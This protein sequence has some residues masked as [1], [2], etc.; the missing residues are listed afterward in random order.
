MSQP[1]TKSYPPRPNVYVSNPDDGRERAVVVDVANRYVFA[2]VLPSRGMSAF[3]LANSAIEEY[4]RS[5]GSYPNS[6]RDPVDATMTRFG[7]FLEQYTSRV[8]L[9]EES[10]RVLG[11]P[12]SQYYSDSAA[13]TAARLGQLVTYLQ[14]VATFTALGPN[15]REAVDALNQRLDANQESEQELIKASAPGSTLDGMM[16]LNVEQ[17]AFHVAA[18]AGISEMPMNP[19]PMGQPP[20]ESSSPIRAWWA[21]AEKVAPWWAKH[22]STFIGSATQQSPGFFDCPGMSDT[23]R[24][25]AIEA[26]NGLQHLQQKITAQHGGVITLPDIVG[27]GDHWKSLF[28]LSALTP[29]SQT[30]ANAAGN[31]A[32][33]AQSLRR[34]FAEATAPAAPKPAA[35]VPPIPLPDPS[36]TSNRRRFIIS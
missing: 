17:V 9:C 31:S 7:H 6:Q 27:Y 2:E 22:S 14:A 35:V 32:P 8:R 25:H 16:R 26:L 5:T 19:Q 23:E 33:F 12:A 13:K 3:E 4:R 18:A 30:L 34:R 21:L 29:D 11:N 1:Q 15:G 20:S 24:I 10:A 36:T 28:V